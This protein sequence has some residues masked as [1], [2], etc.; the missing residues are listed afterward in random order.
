[1][2]AVELSSDQKP[3]R[4]DER[5]RILS[6]GGVVQQSQ[7][8]MRQG[9]GPPR[10]MRVGPERVWDRTGCCGLGVSRSLGDCS[11]HPFVVANPELLER[12]LEMNDKVIILGSD[13]VWDRLRSQEAVDIA[14]RHTDP[15]SAARE[16]TEVARQRWHHET[17]G[18]VSDDI[19]AV[20]VRLEPLGC[21]LEPPPSAP[22]AMTIGGHGQRNRHGLV[23]PD[24]S[25][26][27]MNETD[28]FLGLNRFGS[29]LPS[30]T[31]LRLGSRPRNTRRTDGAASRS[32]KAPVHNWKGPKD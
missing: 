27:R 11:M 12:R 7:Y 16:I 15:T 17:Q 24:K 28:G 19:T 3:C 5:R 20:V 9:P 26:D 8:P 10:L 30:E 31:A 14:S 4:I 1:M 23:A 13:G 18:R 32:R 2:R 25:I 21:A 29:S 6:A 22:A